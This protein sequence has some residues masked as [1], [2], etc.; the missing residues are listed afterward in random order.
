MH[1][2]QVYANIK[3][4]VH[5]RPW[6][7]LIFILNSL[8]QITTISDEQVEPFKVVP[9]TSKERRVVCRKYVVA[10]RVYDKGCIENLE[11]D[12]NPES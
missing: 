12:K 4:I 1:G 3:P 9:A 8:I 6:Y 2:Q 11:N 10:L 7:A 5:D